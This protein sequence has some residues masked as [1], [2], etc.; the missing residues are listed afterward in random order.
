[1]PYGDSERETYPGEVSRKLTGELIVKVKERF[2]DAVD[3]DIYDPRS[4]IWL[5]D[6][7]KFSVRGAEPVWIANG[8][9]LFRGVPH[10]E[11][12]EKALDAYIKKGHK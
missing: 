7:I 8:S 6:I 4:P 10:W 5:W 2:K 11:D 1:M 12:L 3:L 9:L